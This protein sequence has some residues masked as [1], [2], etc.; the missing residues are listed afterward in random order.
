MEEIFVLKETADQEGLHSP[1]ELFAQTE[2]IDIDHAQEHC[3]LFYLD[4]R[5]RVI[6]H[7]VLFKGGLNACLL[8]MKLVFGNALR[9]HACAI[10]MA[11][12]H[13]SGNLRP[14][15]ADYRVLKKLEEAGRLLQIEVRDFLIFNQT[16]F[17][18][19]MHGAQ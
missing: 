12:N 5:N 15:D 2:R 8:D 3:I 16:Q 6:A 1:K 13:P 18:S 9:H 14:S 17:Y 19:C 10:A 11:H 7:E 4:T